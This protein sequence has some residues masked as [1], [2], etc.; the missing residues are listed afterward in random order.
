MMTEYHHKKKKLINIH[1]QIVMF[2]N[3]ITAFNFL[4]KFKKKK[5]KN[6]KNKVE[7]I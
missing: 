4:I 2:R 7:I 3:G 6:E 5:K 1:M